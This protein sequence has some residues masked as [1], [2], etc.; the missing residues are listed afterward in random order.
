MIVQSTQGFVDSLNRLSAAEARTARRFIR[1]LCAA[2]EQLAAGWPLTAIALS[3]YVINEERGADLSAVV[4]ND[5]IYG[6]SFDG[7]YL[8]VAVMGKAPEI[9]RLL[10]VIKKRPG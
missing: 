3:N 4:G 9:C 8:A 5:R 1:P 10:T 6:I 2:V 7:F